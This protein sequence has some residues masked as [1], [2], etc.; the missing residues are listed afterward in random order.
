[1]AV[2]VTVKDPGDMVTTRVKE[3]GKCSSQMTSLS[4]E[5]SLERDDDYMYQE[6]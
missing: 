1:M 6:D 4:T 3:R 5:G 2:A